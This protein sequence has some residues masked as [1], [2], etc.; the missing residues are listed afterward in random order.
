[1]SPQNIAIIVARPSDE[2]LWVGGSVLSNS[3]WDTFVCCLCDEDNP[4]KSTR[5]LKSLSRL[6]TVG[7]IGDL[8]DGPDESSLTEE[9]ISQSILK[10]L[11]EKEFDLIYTHSPEGEYTGNL[12]QEEI[13]K[14]VISL[15]NADL[16]KTKELRQFAYEDGNRQ[17]RP[18]AIIN[19]TLLC[20][21]SNPTWK[22][23]LAIMTDT[24]GFEKSS[25]EAQATPKLEAFHCFQSPSEALTYFDLLPETKA[26]RT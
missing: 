2:A 6:G 16:I 13:G 4:A 17:Y 9:L 18:R 14:A 23:K 26:P 25:W 19:N 5:F 10:L 7:A 22:E 3:T 8:H 15:W 11:P 20:Y 12:G 24:Y 1:M 21:L